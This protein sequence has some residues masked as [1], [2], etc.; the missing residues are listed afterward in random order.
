MYTR[1][2]ALDGCDVQF[3]TDNPRKTHCSL[4]H[5]NLSRVRRFRAKR[6]KGGGNGGP[7]SGGRGGGVRLDTIVTVDPQAIYVP[8]ACYR[9]PP[10]RKPPQSAHIETARSDD[11]LLT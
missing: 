10:A 8:D 6:R 2:C 5:A 4:D 9:T 1:I 7:S 11:A 3:Q